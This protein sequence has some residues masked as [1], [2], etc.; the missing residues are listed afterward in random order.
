MTV[1][2]LAEPTVCPV[3]LCSCCFDVNLLPEEGSSFVLE[4]LILGSQGGHF[5]SLRLDD[6][7]QLPNDLTGCEVRDGV[8]VD[9]GELHSEIV[10]QTLARLSAAA[11]A[12]MERI[13]RAILSMGRI[14]GMKCLHSRIDL[15]QYGSALGV[16]TSKRSVVFQAEK[17][18]SY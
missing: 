17:A 15:W 7:E 11:P 8:E 9:L 14:S 10:Y 18:K 6:V 13:H 12:I 1:L 16:A 4:V 3:V 2:L 5:C